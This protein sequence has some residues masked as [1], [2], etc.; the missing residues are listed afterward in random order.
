FEKA[1]GGL[2]VR[3]ND[4]PLRRAWLVG[5]VMPM[6]A[7]W[8]RA[9]VLAGAPLPGGAPF[10]PRETALVEQPVP[11]EPP[12]EATDAETT[13]S[14]LEPCQVKVRAHA[15]GGGFLVLADVYY[16]GW[17]ATIDGRPAKVYQTDYV[18]RGVVVPPGDHVIEFRYRPTSFYLGL[19]V[20]GLSA[21]GL[22][23]LLLV[24]RSRATA[25]PTAPRAGG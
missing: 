7:D 9:I 14:T 25:D 19:S 20:S 10:R 2:R 13:I 3:R 8:I 1:E 24:R 18:L 16:P 21:A 5:R 22:L 17:R 15:P 6:P 11:F 23:G 4:L 12:A